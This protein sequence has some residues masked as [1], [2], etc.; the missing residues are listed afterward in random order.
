MFA[1]RPASPAPLDPRHGVEVVRV[2]DAGDGVVGGGAGPQLHHAPEVAGG[3][4]VSPPPRPL[5][6]AALAAGGL[7]YLRLLPGTHA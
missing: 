4:S 2:E 1:V 5:R 7:L 3:Q 6:A